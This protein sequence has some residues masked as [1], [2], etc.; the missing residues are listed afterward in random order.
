MTIYYGYEVHNIASVHPGSVPV[1]LGF[2]YFCEVVI[3]LAVTCGSYSL[4]D[5]KKKKKKKT[6]SN[7]KKVFGGRERGQS[8]SKSFHC[9]GE[10]SNQPIYVIKMKR[11]KK[12]K[13][14]QQKKK[15]KR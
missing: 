12:K 14:K 3:P 11:S 5:L 1:S 9:A 7:R 15:K 13:P 10:L 4:V 2:W 8:T 6:L